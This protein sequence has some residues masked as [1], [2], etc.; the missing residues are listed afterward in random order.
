MTTARGGLLAALTVVVAAVH[1]LAAVKPKPRRDVPTLVTKDDA[2]RERELQE[3]PGIPVARLSVAEGKVEQ[4]DG[5][6]PWGRAREGARVLTGDSLRTG[7]ATTAR[8]DFPWMQIGIGEAS[9]VAVRPNRLLTA[10]LVEGRAEQR[11]EAGAQLM[12]MRTREAVIRGDGHV[13]LRREGE[14]TLVT[15]LEG[16]VL[17]TA[18]GKT[19]VLPKGQ[20]ALARQGA[21]PE[22]VSLPPPPTGLVPGADPAYVV[23]GQGVSLAWTG[24]QREHLVQVLALASEDVLLQRDVKGRSVTLDVPWEG[25]FR[26]RVA[27][28]DVSGVEGLPSNAGY[29]C[30]VAK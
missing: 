14:R 21:P 18:G 2:E 8:L 28:R 15:V 4:T 30:R 6:G 29:F 13:V 22:L 20:G 27:T 5:R 3:R 16:R 19:S 23:D 7:P 26:W 17:V 9:V 12:R 11:A 24:A 25:T 10:E 1:A